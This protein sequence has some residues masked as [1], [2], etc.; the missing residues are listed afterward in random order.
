MLVISNIMQFILKL[1][2]VPIKTPLRNILSVNNEPL[3]LAILHEWKSKLPEMKKRKKKLDV[4]NMHLTTLAYE[5]IDNPF[6][7]TNETIATAILEYLKFDTIRF[8]AVENEDLLHRQSRHWDPI[9]GWFEQQFNCHLPIE[10][11]DI[12]NTTSIPK[13]DLSKLHNNLLARGRWPLVGAKFMAQSL[14]SYV[15]TASLTEKFL[16]VEDAVNLARLETNFQ[17]EKWSKVECEHD[18]DEQCVRAR[19]AAGNLFYHLSST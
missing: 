9:V 18:L 16:G 1:N 2:S 7:E 3:A 13:F 14:K 11:G 17:V 5:A 10:Y 4:P 19:A 15:L 8:R 12:T 6:N